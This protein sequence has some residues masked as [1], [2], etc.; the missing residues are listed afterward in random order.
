MEDMGVDTDD[1][2]A[3]VAFY[4]HMDHCIKPYVFSR[5]QYY[6]WNW[7]GE[8]QLYE[9]DGRTVHTCRDFEAIRDWAIEN[10]A[11][12]FNRSI[13]VPDPLLD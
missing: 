1:A 3:R 6:P 10:Q 13:H 5:H 8:D 7:N 4:A 9:A 2:A 12:V 11:G